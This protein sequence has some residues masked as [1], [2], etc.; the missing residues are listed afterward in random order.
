MQEN[1]PS[2][3]LELVDPETR[4]KLKKAKNVA[5][6][7][8]ILDSPNT[9]WA[10]RA[11]CLRHPLEPEGCRLPDQIDIESQLKSFAGVPC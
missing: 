2:K 7:H 11:R 9:K 1:P 4:K 8:Q 10:T 6:I 3:E 5:E